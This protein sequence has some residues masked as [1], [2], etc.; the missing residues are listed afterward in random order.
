MGIIN[1]EE[2]YFKEIEAGDTWTLADVRTITET[3]IVNFAGI[4]GDV[5]PIHLST[6]FSR[7]NSQF[8]G[9]VAH[10]NL[11]FSITSA[12]AHGINLRSFSYGYDD[13]RFVNP[14][15]IGDT[16]TINVEV[17]EATEYND[18]YGRVVEKYDVENQ[19][20]QTVLA[21]KHISL[22]ERR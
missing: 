5:N 4:S 20:G 1:Y 22:V 16:L 3:D 14:V 7:K 21:V 18:E 10:G 13:L 8:D 12:Y 17:V 15:F 11:V 2:R 6:D 9:R 19:D